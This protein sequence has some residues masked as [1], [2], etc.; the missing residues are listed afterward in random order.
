MVKRL[1]PA[2]LLWSAC[3]L[4]PAV[5]Y[6]C[7]ADGSCLQPGTV[8]WPDGYCRADAPGG[9]GGGAMTGG[10]TGG[11]AQLDAGEIDAGEADAGTDAGA[12][13]C[14]CPSNTCGFFNA[15]DGC[16]EFDCGVCTDGLECGVTTPNRCG[17]PR[18]CSPEGWCFENPLPQGNTIRAAWVAGPREVY[19]VGDGATILKWNGERHTRIN[20]SPG[21]DGVDFYGV[22]GRSSSD[23]YVVGSR[24]T[25]LHYANSTYTLENF[26]FVRPSGVL[27]A[28]YVKPDGDAF[29]VGSNNTIYR[30]MSD[31]VWDDEALFFGVVNFNDVALAPD[32]TMMALGTKPILGPVAHL[33][34]QDG[35]KDW[36]TLPPPPMASGNS[37]WVSPDAGFFVAGGIDGG[38]GQPLL[39]AIMR[40]ERDAGWSLVTTAPAELLTVRGLTSDEYFAAGERGTFV[41]VINGA[42]RIT[43]FGARWSALAAISGAPMVEGQWGEVARFIDGGVQSL[44]G[45]HR[46]RINGLCETDA[47]FFAA[48][49]GEPCTGMNC[50]VPLITR[51]KDGGTRW[52][53][54][55]LR[56]P[57]S[58]SLQ[59]CNTIISVLF[60][61]TDSSRLVR[62]NQNSWSQENL[63]GGALPAFT[64][65][66]AWAQAPTRAWIA[67]ETFTG[68]DPYL[69]FFSGIL[70][71]ITAHAV[72]YD[73]GG[74]VVTTVGGVD[75]LGFA[76]G[77][78]GLAFTIERDGGLGPLPRLGASTFRHISGVEQNDGGPLIIAVGDEGAV[79]RFEDGVGFVADQPVVG[80]LSTAYTLPEGDAWLGGTAPSDGGAGPLGRVYRRA[81]SGTWSPVAV[82]STP[83]RT[84]NLQRSDAGLG[85]WL[86]GPGGAILHRQQ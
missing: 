34:G 59:S 25:V 3:E 69:V 4:D 26:T 17:T 77:T 50:T 60:A 7:E 1:L 48:A 24:G 85:V 6:R 67:P 8:C 49:S 68:P 54:S 72:P 10:G 84:L 76:L 36:K 58:S 57:E 39:G 71:T 22:H 65:G 70:S 82:P 14:V 9:G 73:G 11:G 21:L 52:Q 13:T 45:G 55:S 80:D 35:G 43:S 78:N 23:F 42:A 83:V 33:S 27:R 44:S 16:E 51:E 56:T 75:E 41:H 46:G 74:D 15:G 30:R 61:P 29:I 20:A 5:T 18:I 62:L 37:M 64:G 38:A 81:A 63:T 19:F 40:R 32:G 31:G 53:V 86:G 47:G 66:V 2:L 28:V 79:Y 12:A